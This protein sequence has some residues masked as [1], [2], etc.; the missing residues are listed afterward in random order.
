[1]TPRRNHFFFRGVEGVGGGVAG[2]RCLLAEA[3][4]NPAYRGR[5]L[6]R[7]HTRPARPGHHTAARGRG[8]RRAHREASGDAGAAEPPREQLGEMLALMRRH[9]E[10][11]REF[12]AVQE[13]EPR[14]FRPVHG[15]RP[16]TPGGRVVRRRERRGGTS[17]SL[18]GSGDCE[19]ISSSQQPT[20]GCNPSLGTPRT[21]TGQ[22][23]GENRSRAS[24]RTKQARRL[25]AWRCSASAC[26]ALA[27]L[28]GKRRA[29]LTRSSP[30]DSA[31]GRALSRRWQAAAGTGGALPNA[32]D[33]KS[34]ALH[35]GPARPRDARGPRPT[36][37]RVS[38]SED[39]GPPPSSGRC[40]WM[41][42]RT[43]AQ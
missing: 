13:T 18:H 27:L 32:S 6:G 26:W 31:R 15:A 36:L 9:A 28:A 2:A 22:A 3:G 23:A 41:I 24:A 30:R 12:E 19:P 16:G 35:S 1:M 42:S 14:R 17:S 7:L 29:D 37:D 10:A 33:D 43:C 25:S 4:G 34:R 21:I 38:L 8:A 39:F 11:L 5:G 20:S 40:M